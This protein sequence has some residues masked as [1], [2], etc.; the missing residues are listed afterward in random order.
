[1]KRSESILGLKFNRRAWN[2][3]VKEG[4]SFAV[5]CYRT[6]AGKTFY[7]QFSFL[8]PRSNL[9]PRLVKPRQGL[10]M[11]YRVIVTPKRGQAKVVSERFRW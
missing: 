1:M 8:G 3:C 5:T 4:G 11:R 10:K 9:L 7:A 2:H 6:K